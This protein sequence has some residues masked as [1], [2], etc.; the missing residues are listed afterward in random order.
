MLFFTGT[1]VLAIAIFAA[2]PIESFQRWNKYDGA[3]FMLKPHE[4]LEQLEPYQDKFAFA[5][6]GYSASA[7]ISYHARQNFA[8][9]GEASSHARHDDIVTDFRALNGKNI[10]ILLKKEP[11]FSQYGPYFKSIEFKQ[12]NVRGAIFHLVLGR[13][14][15]YRTYREQVLRTV[16]DKYYAVPRY[17]PMGACYFCEKYFPGESCRRAEKK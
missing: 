13:G 12:F 10:A 5:T 17:L 14:F 8:V 9:F 3:V 15:D 7:I 4:I 6:D 11:E 16:K 1:H 2:L